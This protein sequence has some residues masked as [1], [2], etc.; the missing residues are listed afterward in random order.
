MKNRIIIKR[1]RH[2]CRINTGVFSGCPYYIPLPTIDN[3][4]VYVR[5]VSGK[6]DQISGKCINFY[7]F[8]HIQDKDLPAS[9]IGSGKKYQTDC[10][11]DSHKVPD[12]I[13][14]CD[15]NRA[16]GFNLFLEQRDNR[17]IASQ[18]ISETDCHEFCFG[19]FKPFQ[20]VCRYSF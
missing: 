13:R 17:T 9:G 12:D 16:T 3:L 10:L 4:N 8:A 2:T 7:R 14:M 15:S 5:L 1:L 6:S 11:R 20:Y 18:Y 19:G